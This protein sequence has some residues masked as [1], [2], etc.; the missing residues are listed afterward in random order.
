MPHE[1]A[2]QMTA[3]DTQSLREAIDRVVFTVERAL[4]DDQAR[5][6]LDGC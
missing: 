4:L 2:A 3:G 5:C 1:E 6:P